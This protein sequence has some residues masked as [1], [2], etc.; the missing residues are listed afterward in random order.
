MNASIVILV[1]AVALAVAWYWWSRR[2][3]Q[4]AAIG[5]HLAAGTTTAGAAPGALASY[6]EYRRIS[7]SNMLLGKLTC[8]RCGSN[9][10]VARNGTASCSNCGAALYRT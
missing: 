6:D 4:P 7:P 8:N 9:L 5:G 1:A 2:D 10:I 3:K